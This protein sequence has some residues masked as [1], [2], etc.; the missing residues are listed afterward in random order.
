MSKKVRQAT[1]LQS[2]KQKTEPGKVD[3]RKRTRQAARSRTSGPEVGQLANTCEAWVGRGMQDHSD[4]PF[5]SVSSADSEEREVSAVTDSLP[6]RGFRRRET[7]IICHDITSP[8]ALCPPCP[9][10]RK[11]CVTLDVSRIVFRLCLR[12]AEECLGS[13]CLGEVSNLRPS[14]SPLRMAAFDPVPCAPMILR[15]WHPSAK[16]PDSVCKQMHFPP[17]RKLMRTPPHNRRQFQKVSCSRLSH[18]RSHSLEVVLKGRVRTYL[19]N[20]KGV[21]EIY[22]LPDTLVNCSRVIVFCHLRCL[23]PAR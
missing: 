10:D 21:A 4:I 7:V 1:K 19:F 5:C 15:T 20:D 18:Q 13:G 9:V 12:R 16:H 2:P 3:A 8:L 11:G 22:D 23:T 6:P 14:R 17:T